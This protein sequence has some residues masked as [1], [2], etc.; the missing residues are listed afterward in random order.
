MIRHKQIRTTALALV[1]SILFFGLSGLDISIQDFLFDPQ[2]H[3]WLLGKHTQPY[4]FIFYDGIK[5]LLILFALLLL[6]SLLF[7]RKSITIQKYKQGIIIVVLSA[8]IVPFTASTLK[9]YTNMPCP[10]H[11]QHYGG[12]YPETKVWEHYPASFKQPSHIQCWPAGHASGGFALLSLFFL[13]KSRKNRQRAILLGLSVGWIMGG[14]KMLIGDHYFSHTWIT[15]LL[16]WLLILLIAKGVK[17]LS[18]E[19]R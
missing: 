10:K 11:T 12:I 7:L 5:I 8:V 1:A 4:Q 14:Y 3:T 13:F 17:T 15:M 9:K 18:R 6:L 2:T 19:D 16:S